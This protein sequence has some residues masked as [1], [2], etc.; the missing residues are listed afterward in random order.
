MDDLPLNLLPAYP[1]VFP[2]NRVTSRRISGGFS[3]AGVWKISSEAGT[4]AVRSWPNGGLSSGRIRGLHRLLEHLCSCGLKFV[5]SPVVSKAGAT[6]A[7]VDGQRWQIEPWLPGEADRTD[8]ISDE[9]ISNAMYALSEWHAVASTFRPTTET[10]EWFACRT[11]A[12]SPAVSERLRLTDR[13]LQQDLRFVS[14]RL[15]P[16]SEFDHLA[17]R[18]CRLAAEALPLI[19][20]DLLATS[21]VRFNLQPCLRDVW[22]EHVLFDGDEV[23]GIIDPSACRTENVATDLARLIGSFAGDDRKLWDTAIDAYCSRR[24][25]TLIEYQLVRTLDRSAV[26]LSPLTWLRRRYLED[27]GFDEVAVVKRLEEQS[28]RLTFLV[29]RGSF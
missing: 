20:S 13:W 4:F 2:V 16:I 8:A 27:V 17:A 28:K 9:R 5:S 10:R 23:S 7:E 14:D 29:Q 12:A 11:E 15:Q 21:I 24:P 1:D 19:R 18:I 6:L 22:R 25:L 26:V 3:G